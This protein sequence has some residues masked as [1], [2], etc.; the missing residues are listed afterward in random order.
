MIYIV[1]GAPGAGKGTRAKLMCEKLGIPHISTGSLIRESEEITAKYSKTLGTG[2]LLPD[3]AIKEM[4]VHRLEREDA[5]KGFVLDGYPRTIQ[6]VK[7]LEEILKAID[8]K[9]TK[10]FLF[11]TAEEEIYNRILN[12]KICIPC[13][14]IYGWGK[15]SEVPNVC[16]KCG[17]TLTKRPED[18]EEVIKTR[19][20][21]YYNETAPIIS[22]YEELGLLERIDSTDKPERVLERV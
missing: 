17:R 6:Q 3:E 11:E 10:V 9:V 2:N 7:D 12:R 16:E 18:N 5:K 14:K 1:L 20:T 8:R 15:D 22:Y 13:D 21:I 19:L 4:L